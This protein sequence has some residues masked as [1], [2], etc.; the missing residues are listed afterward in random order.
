MIIRHIVIQRSQSC[1]TITSLSCSYNHIIATNMICMQMRWCAVVNSRLALWQEVANILSIGNMRT[2]VVVWFLSYA[3]LIPCK[4]TC[5]YQ[6]SGTI[7]QNVEC[8]LTSTRIYKMDIKITL[9][10]HRQRLPNTGT[11]QTLAITTTR[12]SEQRK[13]RDKK[14]YLLHSSK[15]NNNKDT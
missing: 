14:Q 15:I 7:R 3:I 13:N 4:L 2:S 12:G 9:T 11:L 8:T 5:I 6:H 10:P 1:L